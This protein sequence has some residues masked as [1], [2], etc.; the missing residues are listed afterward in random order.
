MLIGSQKKKMLEQRVIAIQ[1]SSNRSMQESNAL[2]RA[3]FEGE[4]RGETMAQ[5]LE[6]ATKQ[7][8]VVSRRENQYGTQIS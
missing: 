4:I 1:R 8:V 2:S 6:A 3:K 7:S 5:D